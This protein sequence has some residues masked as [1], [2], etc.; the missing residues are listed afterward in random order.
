MPLIGTQQGTAFPLHV[1]AESAAGQ[2]VS[3]LPVQRLGEL[4][5]TGILGLWDPEIIKFSCFPGFQVK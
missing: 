5:A 2:N 3:S 4:R 1:L